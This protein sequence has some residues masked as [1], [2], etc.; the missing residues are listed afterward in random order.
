MIQSVLIKGLSTGLILQLAIGPVFIF[1]INMA[2]QNGLSAGILAA[3]GVTIADYLY[4]VMAIAG[5]GKLLE[6]GNRKRL[7]TVISSAVLI[8]FGLL[9]I[10]KGIGFTSS[11][12]AVPLY[13]YSILKSFLSA[14]IL[15]ISSPLTI[16]FWSGIFTAKA[17][18]Y[19][20]NKRELFFFGLSAGSATF[21]FLG[22]CV[23]ILSVIKV[24]IPLIILQLLNIF[25]GALLA[26]Y[27][28]VRVTGIIKSGI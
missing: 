25:V 23:V 28:I 21:L 12:N 4:I 20:L 3:A 1:I 19:S 24:M 27:G 18:E 5:T 9:L 14:F 8:I 22:V 2:L 7:F 10:R 6:S 16:V 11:D 15:T 17:I 13:N 26:G